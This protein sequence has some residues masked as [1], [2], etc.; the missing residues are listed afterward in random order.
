MESECMPA[1][2]KWLDWCVSAKHQPKW[3]WPWQSTIIKRV[4]GS[5]NCGKKINA[6]GHSEHLCPSSILVVLLF[7][8]NYF[9]VFCLCHFLGGE[10]GTRTLRWVFP[11]GSVIEKRP[12]SAGDTGSIRGSARR[13]EEGNG[14]LLPYSCLENSMD[15]GAWWA[16]VHGVTRKSDT[17]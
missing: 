2:N 9:C 16:S 7:V 13:P 17:I 8:F 12:A 5:M 11:A 6:K 4:R 15:R 3:C 10:N 1:E 14:N